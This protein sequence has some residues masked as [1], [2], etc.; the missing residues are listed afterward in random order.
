MRRTRRHWIASVEVRVHLG[1]PFVHS[2]RICEGTGTNPEDLANECDQPWTFG[3]FGIE[4][5]KA[6]S[7][8]WIGRQAFGVIDNGHVQHQMRSG[9]ETMQHVQDVEEVQEEGAG[10]HDVL[11]RCG[12]IR[13]VA[14]DS[15]VEHRDRHEHGSRFEA[16]EGQNSQQIA[17]RPAHDPRNDGFEV[18]KALAAVLR[19]VWMV[20]VR[21]ERPFEPVSGQGH[22][23]HTEGRG[24]LQVRPQTNGEDDRRL[25]QSLSEEDHALPVRSQP[26]LLVAVVEETVALDE[27]EILPSVLVRMDPAEDPDDQ[28]KGTGQTDG[29]CHAGHPVLVLEAVETGVLCPHPRHALDRVASVRM[30]VPRFLVLAQTLVDSDAVDGLHE[31]CCYG[32]VRL[33][34]ENQKNDDDAGHRIV[35]RFLLLSLQLGTISA[36]VLRCI[37]AGVF[38]VDQRH[39][40]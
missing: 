29:S 7:V 16:I 6:V 25:N 2:L 11:C 9:I 8:R 1:F 24:R 38:I 14:D 33:K 36:A 13:I 27:G 34:D 39:V 26:L 22:Q 21:F 30:I 4:R 3:L 19:H 28:Q 5:R 40:V 37:S 20:L 17:P 10:R 23:K 12:G 15:G 32:A 35:S 31:R 18:L